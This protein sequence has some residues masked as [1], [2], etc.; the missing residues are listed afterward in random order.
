LRKNPVTGEAQNCYRF[1]VEREE[2]DEPLE[3]VADQANDLSLA[4]LS[5]QLADHSSWWLDLL[6]SFLQAHL[7]LFSK[8]YTAEQLQKVIKHEWS[9]SVSLNQDHYP[10][11]VSFFP[12]TFQVI[13]GTFIAQ[14]S[15]TSRSVSIDI[16]V[17]ESNTNSDMPTPSLPVL[18]NDLL[19]EVDMDQ[20]PIDK[21][22]TDTT[23]DAT[24]S[25]RQM[26]RHRIKEARLKAKIS[27]YKAQLQM[28]H[29]YDKYGE[30]Y[31]DSEYD[32]EDDLSDEESDDEVEEIQL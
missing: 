12:N 4:T 24:A 29:Y 11:V 17:S 22:P 5:Q 14:W 18:K 31:E 7:S 8:A 9:S 28:R 15:Y 26:D 27:L 23:M 1:E 19:E 25:I 6:R 2:N 13:G 10:L 32:T 20:I 3:W 30:D 16:P 21:N